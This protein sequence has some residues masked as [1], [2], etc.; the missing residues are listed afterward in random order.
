MG[1]NHLLPRKI[2]IRIPEEPTNVFRVIS[3]IRKVIM[4]LWKELYFGVFAKRAFPRK[5]NE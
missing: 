2:K 3:L 5:K 4:I 1:S